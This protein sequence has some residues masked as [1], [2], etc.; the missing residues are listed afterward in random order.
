M[1]VESKL[2]S[3]LRQDPTVRRP[4]IFEGFDKFVTCDGNPTLSWPHDLQSLVVGQ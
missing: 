2:D 4:C 1:C 3:Y